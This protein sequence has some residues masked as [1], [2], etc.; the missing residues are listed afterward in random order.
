MSAQPQNPSPTPNVRL[1][2]IELS[3]FRRLAQTQVKIDK[4]T[5]ILVGANK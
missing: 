5:T 2:C 4:K 1:A 3:R